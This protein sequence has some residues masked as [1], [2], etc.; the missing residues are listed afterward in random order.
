MSTTDPPPTTDFRAWNPETLAK[1]A[2][3]LKDENDLLRQQV[4][5]LL[6]ALRLEWTKENPNENS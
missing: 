4:K 5:D 1:L 6:N 3:E 2:Q